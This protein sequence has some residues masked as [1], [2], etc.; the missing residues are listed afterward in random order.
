MPLFVL[1][2]LVSHVRRSHSAIV[3]QVCDSITGVEFEY[4]LIINKLSKRIM[5][6]IKEKSVN[7]DG[8]VALW[9]LSVACPFSNAP[10]PFVQEYKSIVAGYPRKK[11]KWT[12]LLEEDKKLKDA[13]NVMAS[14]QIQVSTLVVLLS[15]FASF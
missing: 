12:K 4:G 15:L 9:R 13:K 14:A 8:E 3:L 2:L 10:A 1:G 5:E 6:F 7:H 11:P